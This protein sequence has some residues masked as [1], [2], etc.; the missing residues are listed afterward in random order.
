MGEPVGDVTVTHAALSG[1]EVTPEEVPSAID[2]FPVFGAVAALARG[3]T[4][5]RGAEELRHK[6]SDRIDRLA[7][8]LRKASVEVETFR[9][10][11]RIIGGGR[12]SSARFASHGDHRLAMA[13]GVLSLALPEGGEVEGAEAADVSY[14]GFWQA[15]AGA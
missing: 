13:M 8:E 1:V 5:V 4:V 6:E 14:P 12:L 3:E 15:L 7:G 9:D 11:M 2:E 10:G